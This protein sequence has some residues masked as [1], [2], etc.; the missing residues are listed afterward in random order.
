MIGLRHNIL[1]YIMMSYTLYCMDYDYIQS[2][3]DLLLLAQNQQ[4]QMDYL[5]LAP[6]VAPL[7]ARLL[8]EDY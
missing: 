7:F 6:E 4:I 2:H 3:Y 5:Y 1:P 8:I